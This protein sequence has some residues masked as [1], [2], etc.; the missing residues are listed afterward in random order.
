VDL[1]GD[2]AGDEDWRFG[3]LRG[4]IASEIQS[5]VEEAKK[6][7]F[8]DGRSAVHADFCAYQETIIHARRNARAEAYE[9]AAQI[10]DKHANFWAKVK[11][12]IDEGS[13][14]DEYF[15]KQSASQQISKDIRHRARTG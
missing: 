1:Y 11:F 10:A 15:G 7:G 5:A 8:L 4:L 9:D 6:E 13:D 2:I 3:K 12:D 14:R